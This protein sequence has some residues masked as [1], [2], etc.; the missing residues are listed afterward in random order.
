LRFGIVTSRPAEQAVREVLR[1]GGVDDFVVVALPVP[2]ISLLS[3]SAIASIL[4]S[5]KDLLS[6]LASSDVVIL[7]GTVRG[8]ALEVSKVIGRP[9][10]KGPR[11]LG[12]LPIALR[13]VSEGAR[14]DTVRA[15]DEVLGSVEPRI[16]YSEAFRL[17]DV[18][19]PQRGPPVLLVSE[20]GPEVS[21]A[22]APLIAKRYVKEGADIILVGAEGDTGPEELAR[23]VKV[24][25]AL[26]R[27]VIAEAP[28]KR[29]A[30]EA[31]TAGADGISVADYQVNDVIDL[32]DPGVALVV[33]GDSVEGL[34]AIEEALSAR[35]KLIIDPSLAVPPL[36]LAPS[37]SRY[38]RASA[39]LRSPMLFSA[40]NVT[41]EVEADSA[42]VHALLSLMAVEVRASA[43]LVVEETYK[44]IHGTSEAREALRLAS[45]AYARRSSERGMFSRLLVLKQQ[46]PPPPAQAEEGPRPELVDYVEPDVSTSEYVRIALDHA[47]G[48]MRVTL[49]RGG[50][51]VG[52][53][54]GRHALSLSRALVRR[55]NVSAE[56]AAYI[57]YELAKAELSLK[58]GKTYVQD[59]QIIVPPWERNGNSN[60]C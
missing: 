43:Y 28:S 3:A 41:E 22:D 13:Y 33:G 59:E 24:V 5:R 21:E 52:S 46:L 60:S 26:G 15:A 36:G 12:E 57:G 38:L 45:T 6:Q 39:E 42:G 37:V 11:D 1:E 44:S 53:L 10:F 2:A 8:D 20:V 14:L 25:R 54:E 40:A 4:A 27:P 9:A 17:G 31:L 30:E 16:S 48:L 58:L 50:A 47:R 34:K 49:Y 35:A 56:H 19:V 32:L 18:P 23:R 29:H 7:P 51:A 55:F